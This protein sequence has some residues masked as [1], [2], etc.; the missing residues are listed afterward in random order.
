M[1]LGSRQHTQVGPQ[2][3]YFFCIIFFRY[4]L[5]PEYIFCKP[6]APPQLGRLESLLHTSLLKSYQSLHFT[7]VIRPSILNIFIFHP[8]FLESYQQEGSALYRVSTIKQYTTHPNIIS[9]LALL[10]YTCINSHHSVLSTAN[11]H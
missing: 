2:Q 7:P 1:L 6:L 3:Y 5:R 4:T 8:I 10:G 11:R 9:P